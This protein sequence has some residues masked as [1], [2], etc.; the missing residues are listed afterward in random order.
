MN[1]VEG[2]G[3]VSALIIAKYLY[4]LASYFDQKSVKKII[5]NR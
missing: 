2:G 4:N 5:I 1:T 3:R